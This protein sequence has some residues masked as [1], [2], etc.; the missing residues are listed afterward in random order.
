[1]AVDA[2]P[3]A[4][5]P[6]ATA[7]KP[8]PTPSPWTGL[9]LAIAVAVA[10]FLTSGL[11]FP[12]FTLGDGSHPLEPVM[13]AIVL[14]MVVGNAV[15]LP[16]AMRPGLKFA[17]RKLLP[18]GVILLGARL[19][20]YKIIQ[21]GAVGA[22]LSVATIIAGLGLFLLCIRL[23]WVKRKLGLL[24][25]LGTA[26]CGGTAIVAA[27]P[28]IRADDEDVTFSVATV[29]LVGLIAMFALPLIG[30]A[31]HMPD[32][33]F[34]VWAGLSIHQTPQ[35]IAAGYAYSP[36][37]GDTATI[38][39]LARVSLLAPALIAVG[40]LAHRG[41]AGGRSD[42]AKERR[43][44]SIRGL[45]PMFVLG[46]LAMALFRTLGWLPTFTVAGRTIDTVALCD[47]GS[48]ALIVT[49]MAGVG[50]ETRFAALRTTG[51]RPLLLGAAA[52]AII[53]LAT[54]AAIS[55]AG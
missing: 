1:M 21:V 14:G 44:P 29:T 16:A 41:D 13:L 23:G 36:G 30:R 45:L 53:T 7:P 46:F 43:P 3:S 40:W 24:L 20:F 51:P 49:A 4:P 42:D 38:V 6:A 17:S 32:T 10:A 33:A 37:A 27:A 31:T 34:G 19:D 35:V 18:A 52:A 28:V 39:K 54:A 26:I 15:D 11:P 47:V 2:I 8:S 55:V 25:G 12:P 22:A 48:K 9:L 50:L 5:P